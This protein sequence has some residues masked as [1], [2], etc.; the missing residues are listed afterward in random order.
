MKKLFLTFV[1]AFISVASFAQVKFAQMTF[2]EAQAKAKASGKELLLDVTMDEKDSP[3][4][5]KVFTGKAD[6]DF[7]NKN[8]VTARINMREKENM[9]FG[10]YLYSLMYPC[11][12]FYTNKGEQLEST[13]W[14]NLADKKDVIELAKKSLDAAAVKRANTRKIEFRDLDYKQALEAAKEEGKL[15]FIDNYT[16]WCRPCKQMDMDVFTLNTVADYYNENFVCIKLDADKDPYKVAKTNGVRGFP[17]YLYMDAEGTVVLSEGGF[18]PERAFIDYG[19]NAIK[20]YNDNQE[21]NLQSLSL[22]EAKKLAKKEG[23]N[24][25]IDL[26]ATWCGPCKQLKATT[27]KSPAV[28]R[29]YNDNFISVYV[30][31]DIEKEIAEQM[32]EA[33]GYSAFP[34][35]VYINADGE[36]LH[37]Y[38]GAGFSN[39]AFIAEGQKAVENRG[40]AAFNKRYETGDNVDAAFIKEYIVI[41]GN[42]YEKERAAVVATEYLDNLTLENLLIAENFKM[43]KD[44]VSELDTKPTQLFSENFDKFHEAFGRDAEHYRSLLWNRKSTSYVD[45]DADKPELDKAGYKAFLKRLDGSDL[46]KEMKESI[47]KSA[48]ITN[49]ENLGDWKTYVSLTTK[50]I[51]KQ[52]AKASVG[53]VYNQGLKVNQKCEDKK[54]RLKFAETMKSYVAQLEETQ[55]ENMMVG[56]YLS[57]MK[58]TIVSLE[59]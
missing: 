58:K 10:K 9:S 57:A 46:P 45:R 48:P 29:Y 36:M 26:S 2:E 54:L 50:D 27:F 17:G 47:K 14:H 42:S 53:V 19:V 40:L 25:F 15:L 24:I 39:E 3:N 16:S 55:K 33:Y 44:N 7:I 31:C 18:T 51:K 1:A 52:G 23:K 49:A 38:V 20:R 41:L 5:V 59:E 21:I 11:V 13:N 56:A 43:L 34:T 32:K 6:A 37:K 4:I 35:M 28:A 22:D 12:V 8:F 30:E